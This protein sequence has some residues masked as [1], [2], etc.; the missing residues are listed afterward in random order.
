MRPRHWQNLT[1]PGMKL[2]C[3]F[4]QIEPAVVVRQQ[5]RS[6]QS[7]V[8]ITPNSKYFTRN[9]IDLKQ[10]SVRNDETHGGLSEQIRA[11]FRADLLNRAWY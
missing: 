9:R 3:K 2:S 10:Q 5:G 6:G 7:L 1:K 8:V 11:D 4:R